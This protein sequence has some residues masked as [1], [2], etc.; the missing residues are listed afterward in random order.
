MRDHRRGRAGRAGRPRRRC[1]DRAGG[2]GGAPPAGS[3]G[4]R[5]C[6]RVVAVISAR[7]ASSRVRIVPSRSFS[8]TFPVKPSVTTTSEAPRED[9]APLGVALEVEVARREELVR[10]ERQLVPLLR[11]LADREEPHLRVRDAEDL[12]G[13]DGAHRRELEEVLRPGVGV[14]AAV[15]QH[16]RA[17]APRDRDGDRRPHARRGCGAARG[18]RPRASRR[19][20]RR[21]R[22]RRPCP[23]RRRGRRRRASSPASRARLRPAS[24][25]SRSRPRSS[26]SSSPRGSIDASPK[27]IGSIAVG[28]RLERARDDLVGAAVTAHRVDRDADVIGYGASMRSGSTSRPLYVPQVRQR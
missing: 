17:A 3:G 5:A 11:L 26:W 1:P 13:E 15:E 18:G 16:R 19:C 9:V 28:A 24:R 6:R 14:R 10:L 25:P 20:S 23:P 4:R 21:R 12:L 8:V 22:R 7:S 27:R 2:G